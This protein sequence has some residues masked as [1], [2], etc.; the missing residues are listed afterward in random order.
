[1]MVS[2][3]PFAASCYY[4]GSGISSSSLRLAHPTAIGGGG[5]GLKAGEVKTGRD[6]TKNPIPAVN[7]IGLKT[8]SHAD[9]PGR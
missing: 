4:E 5:A 2:I 1:M 3:R 6:A 9:A 8:I 7:M